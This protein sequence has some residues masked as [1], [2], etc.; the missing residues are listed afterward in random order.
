MT[1]HDLLPNSALLTVQGW[2]HATLFLS[3]CAD[4][5]VADYFLTGAVPPPGTVCQQDFIPFLVP[6]DGDLSAES[7]EILNRQTIRASIMDEVAF[8]PPGL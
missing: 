8:I 3:F 2:G 1:A 6:F 5:I 4:A 7:Q